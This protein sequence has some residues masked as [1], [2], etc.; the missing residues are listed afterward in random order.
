M[1]FLSQSKYAKNLVKRFGLEKAKYFKTPMSITLKLSKDKNSVSVDPT[2]YRTMIC[3]LFILQLAI[4]IFVIVLV[5]V[6]NTNPI[7][8]NLILLILRESLYMLVELLIMVFRILRI[9]T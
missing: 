3:S 4:L 8:K 5:F 7:L 1:G 9:L 6:Q 2:L